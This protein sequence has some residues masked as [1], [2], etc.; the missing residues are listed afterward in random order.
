MRQT[1]LRDA[2]VKK[3]WRAMVTQV[4]RVHDTRKKEV[5]E[6]DNAIRSVFN[7]FF[8]NVKTEFMGHSKR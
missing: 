5:V 4:L 7:I 3:L 1:L 6:N 2:K 8:F